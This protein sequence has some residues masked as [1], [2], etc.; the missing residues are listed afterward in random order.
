M[1]SLIW[2][3]L[4][5]AATRSEGAKPNVVYILVDDLGWGDVNYASVPEI[6]TPNIKQLKDEGIEMTQFY[7][8]SKCTASRAAIMSGRYPYKMGV[9]TQNVFT[10]YSN[11]FLSLDNK[12]MPAYLKDQGY[13]THLVGKWHLGFC[14]ELHTPIKRGF[15]TSFGSYSNVESHFIGTNIG[16]PFDWNLNNEP[17]FQA[18][19]SYSTHL[20]TNRTRQLL[21]DHFANPASPI[22]I[23]AAYLAPHK[24]VEVPPAYYKKT[25]CS[26]LALKEPVEYYSHRMKYCGMVVAVD[27]GIGQIVQTLRD[28]GQLENTVIIFHSDNGAALDET[29]ASSWDLRGSKQSIYEG[30]HRSRS[31]I[32]VGKNFQPDQGTPSVYHGLVHE[33]D[34][35]PT[36]FQAAGGD[37]STLPGGL[38]G[39]SAWHNILYNRPSDRHWMVY[40][41]DSVLQQHAIRLK[42]ATHNFK[43]VFDSKSKVAGWRADVDPRPLAEH[44]EDPLQRNKSFNSPKDRYRLFNMDINPTE[45]EPQIKDGVELV[46]DAALDH[47]EVKALLV[48]AIQ[49]LLPEEGAQPTFIKFP[50]R[51]HPGHPNYWTNIYGYPA[52]HFGGCN[53]DGSIVTEW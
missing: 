2:L 19:G 50:G 49:D 16:K 25:D 11:N 1:T 14:N 53:A 32:R 33:V 13:A 4:L 26:K 18:N 17:Y 24:P 27:E 15:D 46:R 31:I 37:P 30:G 51:G 41:V 47:P 40:N 48:Q 28:L 10:D 12:L 52:F 29:H 35:L 22:F 34:M 45:L 6:P 20:V 8:Q 36:L 38:D 9:S 44:M 5:V 3:L 21:R 7:T 39:R 23:Y 42:N 43:L